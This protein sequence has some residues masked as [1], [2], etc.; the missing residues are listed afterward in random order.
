MCRSGKVEKLFRLFLLTDKIRNGIQRAEKYLNSHKYIFWILF[1]PLLVAFAVSMLNHIFIWGNI[2]GIVLIILVYIK[3]FLNM[4]SSLR[5][6]LGGSIL[7]SIIFSALVGVITHTLTYNPI[8]IYLLEIISFGIVWIFVS[9]IA[10]NKI[11]TISNEI[12]SI[13]FSV[14]L[15]IKDSVI[16]IVE[17]L[18]HFTVNELEMVAFDMIIVPLIIINSTSTVLC[19]LKGYYI[20]KYGKNETYKSKQ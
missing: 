18:F 11:S 16:R 12:Y 10:D 19:L 9:L 20:E 14:I 1:I 4:V 8:I 3:L 5:C 2:I 6:F 7:F 13:L 15:I 17:Y